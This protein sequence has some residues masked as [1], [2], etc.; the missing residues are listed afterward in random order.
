MDYSDRAMRLSARKSISFPHAN[1]LQDRS[2]FDIKVIKV[3]SRSDILTRSNTRSSDYPML[4][5]IIKPVPETDEKFDPICTLRALY[6]RPHIT[7]SRS[8]SEMKSASGRNSIRGDS[9]VFTFKY[10]VQYPLFLATI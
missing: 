10:I 7:D 9:F 5:G 2:L 1:L 8:E 3:A 6:E 4:S